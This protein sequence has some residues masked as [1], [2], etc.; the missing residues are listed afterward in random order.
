MKKKTSSPLAVHATIA[1][2]ALGG[3]L[4]LPLLSGE[5]LLS[6][7]PATS[8]AEIGVEHTMP[9]TLALTLAVT[10]E[11]KGILEVS[12]DAAETV[13]VS[14][15]ETW[16]LWEVRGKALA[17]IKEDAPSFGFIRWHIPAG[18]TLS[19]R[20]EEIP[21]SLSAENPSGVS[22]KIQL[23]TV[24]LVSEHVGRNVILVKNARAKIW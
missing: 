24:D 11:A 23:T 17:D 5:D 8:P 6:T 10:D 16:I 1:A 18:A 3:F 12:H 15:P 7:I 9:A 4:L 22:L 13:F 21:S 14:L 19:F 20:L 2:A